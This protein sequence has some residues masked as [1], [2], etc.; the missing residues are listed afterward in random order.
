MT[1]PKHIGVILDGNRRFAKRLMVKPWKG[2]EWGAKKFQEFLQ[3]CFD[4]GVEEV[5]AYA[6]SIQNFN[7]PKKEFDYI[8]DIFAKELTRMLEKEQ[9]DEFSKNGVRLSIIG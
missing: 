6:F 8:M 7:R 2:H 4:I 1:V 9:L 3:W 5:T